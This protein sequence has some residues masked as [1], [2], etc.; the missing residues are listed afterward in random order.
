MDHQYFI[1]FSGKAFCSN[2]LEPLSFFGFL[3]WLKADYG[4]RQ[5]IPP[6][7][8]VLG[9]AHAFPLRDFQDR[10][11]KRMNLGCQKG[12]EVFGNAQRFFAD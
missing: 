3:G 8:A 9:N 2:F 5:E 4:R 11:D 7:V 6:D 10:W 1:L 12:W